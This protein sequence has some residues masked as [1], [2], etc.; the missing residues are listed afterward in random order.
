MALPVLTTAEDVSDLIGYL[1]TKPTGATLAEA[2]AAIKKSV[3]DPR[4]FTAYTLWGFVNKEGDRMKLTERGWDFARKPEAK[5][6]IYRRVI[7]S[8]PPYKSV[9]E[10]AYHQKL[11]SIT[12]VDVAAHWHE[13]HKDALGTDN[14]D[15]IKNTAVCFFR[16]AE[17]AGLGTFVLGRHGQTTRFDVER[18]QL[19]RYIEAGPS[20]PPWTATSEETLAKTEVIT[21]PDKLAEEN[22]TRVTAPV[23]APPAPDPA[24]Q[25]TKL[26]AIRCFISHGSNINMVDQ[27]Q[28]MLG[29][30][31]ISSEVAVKEETSAIPVPEKVFGAMRRCTTGIIIVSVDETR[32]DK[33]GKFTINENVLIEIGAAFVL[34]E[35]RVV[36]LWDKRLNVPSNLQGLYRCEYEGNE[37]SW[38]CRDEADEGHPRV[39]DHGTSMMGLLNSGTTNIPTLIVAIYA[40]VVSTVTGLVQLLNYRR[41]QDK[42]KITVQKDL[43]IYG[44]PR[45]AN[46]TLTIVK[47][48][49]AGRRPVT[50]TSIGVE[51][52]FPNPHGVF[53]EHQP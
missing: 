16:I 51:C 15:T 41:D 22:V 33:E 27:V 28:T 52:L 36:L 29:L 1:K 39:Q 42:I 44:D 26:T 35:K 10:W 8:I 48:V 47:V 20:T 43:Q 53:P 19:K 32:K 4:K 34:Y 40:A 37:L 24:T 14:E 11:E 6:E 12:N 7:D 2:K 21:D 38:S 50:I 3:L 5:Q 31:D 46:K 9:L 30:A 18:D 49:N 23:G 13:H 25:G 45:Y 17:A